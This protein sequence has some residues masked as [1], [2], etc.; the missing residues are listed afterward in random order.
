MR[1]LEQ[2][3]ES[4]AASKNCWVGPSSVINASDLDA[5]TFDDEDPFGIGVSKHI[6]L[7]GK[8][9]NSDKCLNE[10]VWCLVIELLVSSDASACWL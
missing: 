10:N 7:R 6:A 3:P 1:M 9:S 5:F 4:Q 2:G 8:R